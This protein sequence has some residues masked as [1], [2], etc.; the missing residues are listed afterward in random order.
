[1]YVTYNAQPITVLRPGQ[2]IIH[3]HVYFTYVYIHIHIYD[4]LLYLTGTCSSLV[5]VICNWDSHTVL[6]AK[7]KLLFIVSCHSLL[8]ICNKLVHF[9]KRCS[10]RQMHFKISS[11][12]SKSSARLDR[13]ST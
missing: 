7:R 1:M 8:F 13:S 4:V 9:C 3:V 2:E 12:S 6:F 11:I 10:F 5:F